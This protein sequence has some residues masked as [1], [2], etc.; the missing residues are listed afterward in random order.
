[1]LFDGRPSGSSIVTILAWLGRNGEERCEKS[2]RRR[3]CYDLVLRE[4]I[5]SSTGDA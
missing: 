2:E 4:K 3:D 5:F 1:V